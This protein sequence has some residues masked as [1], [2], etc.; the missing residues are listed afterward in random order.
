MMA[1]SGLGNFSGLPYSQKYGTTSKLQNSTN[2]PNPQ[3][4]LGQKRKFDFKTSNIAKKM[5]TIQT[6]RESTAHRRVDLTSQDE[7]EIKNNNK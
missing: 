4:P 7:T 6:H 3:T 2:I 1:M 5:K